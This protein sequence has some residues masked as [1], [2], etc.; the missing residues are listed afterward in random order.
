MYQSFYG[1]LLIVPTVQKHEHNNFGFKLLIK[2]YIKNRAAYFI[3]STIIAQTQDVGQL[4]N[5]IST[6]LQLLALGNRRDGSQLL[7]S[8]GPARL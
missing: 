2:F 4:R 6:I 1:L 8:N 3:R 7:A 5:T